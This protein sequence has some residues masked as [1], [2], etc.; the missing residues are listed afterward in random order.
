M[1][2][3]ERRLGRA[4]VG[5][6]PGAPTS[7]GC[8]ECALPSPLSPKQALQ[9]TCSLFLSSSP[10]SVVEKARRGGGRPAG[11]LCKSWCWLGGE[12]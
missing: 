3:R 4:G 5:A 9:L 2:V 7:E 1:G 11:V 10:L 6:K 12:G 8:R